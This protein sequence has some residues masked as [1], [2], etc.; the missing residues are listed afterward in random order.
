V[1]ITKKYKDFQIRSTFLAS[2]TFRR[3]D[4]N[5]ILN[6]KSQ[7]HLFF[8]Y[9]SYDIIHLL[10]ATGSTPGGDSTVHIYTQTI[11]RTTQ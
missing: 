6:F 9:F 4:L 11:H 8:S 2:V 3:E 10:T 1:S 7:P 5:F